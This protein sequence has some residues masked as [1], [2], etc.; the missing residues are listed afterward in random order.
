MNA[1]HLKFNFCWEMGDL[2]TLSIYTSMYV[3]WHFRYLIFE[4]FFQTTYVCIIFL[5]LSCGTNCFDGN[6]IQM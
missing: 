2:F 6:Q 4:V 5:T 3:K 1:F